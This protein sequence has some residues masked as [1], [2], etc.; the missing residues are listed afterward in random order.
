MIENYSTQI[1]PSTTKDWTD[2]TVEERI[3]LLRNELKKDKLYE[4][5]EPI[6]APDNGQVVI[7]VEKII[8]A[9][10]RGLLL[11][12]LEQKLKSNI[13]VGITIWC[14]PVGDKSKLRNLRG[15]SFEKE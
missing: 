7:R 1:T 9:N 13:D 5:F 4:N 12:D 10:E 6:K 8:P 14:E 11:L 3:K 15:I 2:K